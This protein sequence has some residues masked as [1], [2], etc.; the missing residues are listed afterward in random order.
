[1]PPDP[2]SGSLQTLNEA[3]A[4]HARFGAEIEAMFA[5]GALSRED[6]DRIVGMRRQL[7]TLEE[8]IG[9]LEGRLRPKA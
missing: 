9:E 8:L 5:R 4:L 1:M 2:H 7:R 3:R 6:W